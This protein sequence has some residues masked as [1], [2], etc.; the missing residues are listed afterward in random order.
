MTRK[1][2]L[3][4]L[5]SCVSAL[6]GSSFTVI[7]T[8]TYPGMT[9]GQSGTASTSGT[10]TFTIQSGV[11]SF[12]GTNI[13]VNGNIVGG[14]T[15]PLV[16][17]DGNIQV[18]GTNGGT[19][20]SIND[21]GSISAA[22]GNFGVDPYGTLTSVTV[23]ADSNLQVGANVDIDGN[24]SVIFANGAMTVDV[25]GNITAYTFTGGI[26]SFDSGAITS[27]GSGELTVGSFINDGAF[28]SDMGRITS[29]GA[30]DFTVSDGT[31]A[32]YNFTWGGAS[33]LNANGSVTLDGGAITSDGSGDMAILGTASFVGGGITLNDDASASFANGDLIVE[34]DGSLIQ[35]STFTVSTLPGGTEGQMTYVTD[36]LA[37]TYLTPVVGGGSTVCPV[38][39]DG[40][41]W[42]CH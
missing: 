34:D 32:A 5:L 17:P 12:D 8:G 42:V 11:L 7:P 41:N 39:F 18:G 36:A 29:D 24:G 27:N 20:T 19:N 25:S 1:I 15:W 22:T 33:F 35:A 31:V 10:G 9:V 3:L 14:A 37:P 13:R 26:I 40:T 2:L 16:S 4:F 28:S 21:D 30:G 23:R 6:A 38:F